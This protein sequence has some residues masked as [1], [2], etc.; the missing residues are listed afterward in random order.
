MV[1]S[2]DGVDCGGDCVDGLICL[3]IIFVTKD[4]RVVRDGI[5]DYSTT[6]WLLHRLSNTV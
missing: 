6:D 1:R 5:D 4:W 3:I 2:S